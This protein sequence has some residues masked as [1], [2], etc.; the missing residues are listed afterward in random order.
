MEQPNLNYIKELAGGD[1]EFELNFIQIL[2]NELPVEVE[3]YS[4]YILNDELELASTVVHKLKHKF[5]ILSMENAYS[6][7]VKYEEE[8][9]QGIT[10]MDS[11]FKLI[12]N[13]V[14][15]YLTTL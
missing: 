14:L 10:E 13:Q 6:Y 9:K 1:K 8:L 15:E 3:Q 2:K 11:E 12:L 5:N 7:A 4:N